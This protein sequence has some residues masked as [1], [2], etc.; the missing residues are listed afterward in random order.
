M[1]EASRRE[2]IQ[3]A[4]A[5]H[6]SDP[7]AE[8]REFSLSRGAVTLPIVKVPLDVPVLNTKSFRVA[9]ALLDHHAALS[10]AADPDNA[11][12]QKVISDL[13]R[14]SHSNAAELRKSLME[15]GQ[16]EPG[17]ITRS[18]VLINANSR[19]VLMRDLHAEGKLKTTFLKVAVLPDDVTP[20][21][22]YDLEAVL[23]KQADLKDPYDLVSELMML[24]TLHTEG[25]MTEQ[26]I[27][28]RQRST[29]AHILQG[30]EILALMERSRHLKNPA[31]PIK[32]FGGPKSQRENWKT[33]LTLVSSADAT[34]HVGAGDEVLRV[35]LALHLLRSANVHGIRTLSTDWTKDQFI[36]ALSDSGD[37]GKKIA[38]SL[39]A[40]ADET[41][42]VPTDVDESLDLLDFGDSGDEHTD[43][44][45]G[46][47]LLN[48]AVQA[49]EAGF[50]DITLADG[51]QVAATDVLNTLTQV[52]GAVLKDEENR[53]TAGKRFEA[54]TLLL[55]KALQSAT[56]A[57][58]AL[59]K[60]VG[61]VA[62]APHAADVE[63]MLKDIEA[64]VKEARRWLRTVEK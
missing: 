52:S 15:D 62:F 35:F 5:A 3:R 14:E 37:L 8:R 49:E 63:A 34:G 43:G 39:R 53:L 7:S 54:P 1:T 23:Q 28:Q 22:L 20:S 16:Q 58:N 61:E 36:D 6:K 2:Q 64:A 25:G 41:V 19:C 56:K 48:I 51:S 31:I 4:L 9:P 59:E 50:S 11:A 13:V 57:N 30:F 10:V 33:M 38:A 18:G 17:V 29:P 46:Q 60:V 44:S 27:A 12:S 21:E 24:K 40:T 42:E 26:A 45:L 47:A 32:R 55:E